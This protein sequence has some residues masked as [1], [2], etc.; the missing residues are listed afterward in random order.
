MPFTDYLTDFLPGQLHFMY[1]FALFGTCYTHFKLSAAKNEMP[2]FAIY[3]IFYFLFFSAIP[4]KEGRFML[5]VTALLM[6]MAAEHIYHQYNRSKFN[7]WIFRI[8]IYFYMLWQVG[9]FMYVQLYHNRMWEVHRHILEKGEPVHSFYTFERYDVA[10]NNLFHGY[11]Q[12][13]PNNVTVILPV[14]YSGNFARVEF[15][16]PYPTAIPLEQVTCIELVDGV[17]RGEFLP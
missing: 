2:Y 17:R 7:R 15:G 3:S 4:H 6:L 12:T 1:P 14:E 5:P 8:A 11:G 9:D 13:A 10:H 16:H